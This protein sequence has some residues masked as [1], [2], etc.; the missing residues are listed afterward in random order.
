MALGMTALRGIGVL[1][2]L[3][4]AACATA[5]AV[6]VTTLSPQTYAFELAPGVSVALPEGG[7][8][9]RLASID[10]SR[11]PASVQCMWAGSATLELRVAKPGGPE[12]SLRLGTPGPANATAA[13]AATTGDLALELVRL[14]PSD[15]PTDP[16]AYRAELRARI[17]GKLEKPD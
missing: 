13:Q 10:D 7:W 3:T 15:P 5:T 11:C 1:T 8:V 2:L 14:L 16:S 17:G 12:Q 4:V 6:P 9:V